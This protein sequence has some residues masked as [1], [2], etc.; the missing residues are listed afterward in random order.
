MVQTVERVRITRSA[1]GIPEAMLLQGAC[2]RVADRP[3]RWSGR[4][5]T[6]DLGPTDP[7]QAGQQGLWRFRA[8]PVSG[9]GASIVV[10]VIETSHGWVL[11]GLVP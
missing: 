3:R 6:W 10:D 11:L 4:G 2:F 1:A 5:D 8:L 7:R 9:V